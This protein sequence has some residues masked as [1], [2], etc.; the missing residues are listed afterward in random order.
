MR[1][2]LGVSFLGSGV[3]GISFFFSSRFLFCFV[4]FFAFSVGD[5]G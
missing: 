5:F 1:S 3:F 2:L 4:Y